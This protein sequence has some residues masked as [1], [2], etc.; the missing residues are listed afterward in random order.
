MIFETKFRGS[1]RQLQDDSK[2]FTGHPSI[3]TARVS[4]AR[5]VSKIARNGQATKVETAVRPNQKEGAGY[6][7]GF[8]QESGGNK[9][10]GIVVPQITNNF[11][12][13]VIAGVEEMAGKEKYTTIICQ[14]GEH[15]DKEKAAVKMLI[16]QNV[17]CIIISLSA[18]TA[19]TRK[20]SHLKKAISHNIKVIQFDRVDE[21]LETDCVVNEVDNV[22]ASIVG[23]L[24]KEGY[25]K[26]A[27]LAGPQE[28][29]I[30][31]QRK[32][33]FEKY[34]TKR[35]VSLTNR[36]IAFYDLT[37]ESAKDAATRLLSLRDRPDAIVAATDLGALGV[38][39]VANDLGL[40]MPADLGLCGFSNEYYTELVSPN[41]TSAD[42][43]SFEM[44]RE[45]ATIF[46]D[47]ISDG[48]NKQQKPRTITLHPK[49]IVR[50]SSRR[51]L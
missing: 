18:E 1:T 19:A 36:P 42:Q 40:E 33:A 47:S 12:A 14:S 15:I 27:C 41:I 35:G 22:T 49:L 8:I 24:V 13:G 51:L 6:A 21:S 23:H 5:T 31:R 16:D 17:S 43:L 11:F 50:A 4:T 28:I 48:G 10:I 44:G 7:N 3:V 32:E 34:M 2:L 45:A 39:D 29:D 25:K 37:R 30:F 20:T 38:W 26:I 46:F 9:V